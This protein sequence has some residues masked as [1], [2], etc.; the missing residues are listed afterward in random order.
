[1]VHEGNYLNGIVVE[2]LELDGD[3]AVGSI[4]GIL[5]INRLAMP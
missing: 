5:I 3:L 4:M 2:V 1:L